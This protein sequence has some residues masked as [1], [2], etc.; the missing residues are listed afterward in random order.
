M[1]YFDLDA[2]KIRATFSIESARKIH[3]ASVSNRTRFSRCSQNEEC[4]SPV[5]STTGLGNESIITL[6]L[7]ILCFCHVSGISRPEYA[8]PRF[9]PLC[10]I[11]RR[12]VNL[13]SSA[14]FL[15]KQ[16]STLFKDLSLNFKD[17]FILC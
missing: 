5:G 13:T 16:I 17:D 9:Q 2:G 15:T 6:S 3:T 7:C 8:P 11:A 12:V 4:E 14:N 10:E 1:K